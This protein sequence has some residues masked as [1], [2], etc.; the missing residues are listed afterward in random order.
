MIAAQHSIMVS[1]LTP[2]YRGCPASPHPCQIGW[3]LSTEWRAACRL[4]MTSA[5]SQ[6]SLAHSHGILSKSYL[7][8]PQSTFSKSAVS[9][10]TN[11]KPRRTP[12][13]RSNS[14]QTHK[15]T[16]PSKTPFPQSHHRRKKERND[17]QTGVAGLVCISIEIKLYIEWMDEW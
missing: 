16:A 1:I 11:N 13:S 3:N 17:P 4:M 5:F 12:S 6:N 9:L 14:A 2:L 7:C 15:A 8:T 10:L